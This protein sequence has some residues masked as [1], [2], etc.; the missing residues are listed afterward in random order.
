[1]P[2]EGQWRNTYLKFE[3]SLVNRETNLEDR[4]KIWNS[5]VFYNY[6]QCAIETARNKRDKELYNAANEAFFQVLEYFQPEIVIVWGKQLWNNIAR[7]NRWT[8]NDDFIIDNYDVKNGF[9]S[10]SNGKLVKTFAIYHPSAAYQWDFW[11]SVIEKM[12]K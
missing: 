8:D 12:T 3:R 7:D 5:F 11:H 10:L 1:M 9:Y 4:G 6:L 2:G